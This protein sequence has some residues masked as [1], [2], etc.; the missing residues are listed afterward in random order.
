[1]QSLFTYSDLEETCYKW[2]FKR[3]ITL[4]PFHFMFR[5]LSDFKT[6]HIQTRT[7]H[8]LCNLHN[9]IKILILIKAYK[10]K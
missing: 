8:Y 5:V 2:Y 3:I 6:I 1:M 10:I 9:N 4:S 7:F